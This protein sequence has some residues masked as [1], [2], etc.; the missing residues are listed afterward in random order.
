[1]EN[2]DA[3]ERINAVW[4]SNK[5]NRY[6]AKGIKKKKENRTNKLYYKMITIHAAKFKSTRSW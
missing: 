5:I 6:P 4:K 1:M 3:K 2:R